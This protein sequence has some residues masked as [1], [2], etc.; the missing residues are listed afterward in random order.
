MI[1]PPW[2][3]LGGMIRSGEWTRRGEGTTNAGY[4]RRAGVSTS[5]KEKKKKAPERASLPGPKL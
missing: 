3:R 4:R 2:I 1:D 5:K